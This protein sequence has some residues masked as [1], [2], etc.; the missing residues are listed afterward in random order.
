MSR[1]RPAA[2]RAHTAAGAA[3]ASTSPAADTEPWRALRLLHGR[4]DRESAPY[5]GVQVESASLIAR[6]LTVCCC[7]RAPSRADQELGLSF[8]QTGLP[9]F[10]RQADRTDII[11]PLGS[12]SVSEHVRAERAEMCTQ[13]IATPCGG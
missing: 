10:N 4:W 5:A 9:V 11:Q 6:L 3:C 1:E 2:A 12:G 7:L 8:R 13:P